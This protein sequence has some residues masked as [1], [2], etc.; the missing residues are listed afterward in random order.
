MKD[1]DDDKAPL[2]KKRK[3]NFAGTSTFKKIPDGTYHAKVKAITEHEGDAG[4]YWKW[5]FVIVEDGDMKGQSPLPYITSFAATALWN[6][7][8][9]L[10]TLGVEV[11][12]SEVSVNPK[13]Y[14]DLELMIRIEE[15]EYKGKTTSKVTDFSK[16]EETAEVEEDK[17]TED[18]E[19]EEK[20]E[21]IEEE[22]AAEEE[23]GPAKVSAEEVRG[24][25]EKELADL[26][27]LHGLKLNLAKIEKKSKKIAAVIDA[28][29]G[30]DLLADE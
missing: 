23:E 30:K 16:I 1:K 6:L 7:R 18:E 2:A 14:L 27:K 15:E 17:P 4:D 8:N 24:M 12:E 3:V 25:D 13:D 20:E 22:A 11:P 21:E 28:L 5:R 10:E 26:V 9:L 29:E 19:D